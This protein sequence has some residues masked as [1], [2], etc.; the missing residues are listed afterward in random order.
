MLT[1]H[2]SSWNFGFKYN[3]RGFLAP[4]NNPFPPPPVV[5]TGKAGKTYPVKWQ[6]LDVNGNFVST[7]S[8]ITDIS[9]KPPSCSA[10]SNDPTDALETTTQGGTALRYDSTANQY[11]Y[12]WATPP[13]GC[14]TLFVKLD[15]GTSH[16]AFFK[17][18]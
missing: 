5:N 10:F 7:L 3:F 8:A 17:F 14:Y 16:Y 6:L 15:D 13:A 1:S 18:S 2:A 11:V 12:N 9:F 4:V